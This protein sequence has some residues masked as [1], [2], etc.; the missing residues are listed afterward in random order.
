MSYP[1]WLAKVNKK[2]FNPRAVRSGKWPVVTHKG[3]SSGTT[4]RTPADAHPTVDGFVLVVRYGLES[5]WVRNI[6]SAGE[7][8][9]ALGD[10]VH[11]L[12]NPVLATQKEAVASLHPDAE[13]GKDFFTAEHYLLMESAS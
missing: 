11:A 13:A 12:N 1:R 7:A 5:D 6:L 10:H 9:L 8:E 2:L 3:R 4:Y